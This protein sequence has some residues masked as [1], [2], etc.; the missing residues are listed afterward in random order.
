MVR[1]KMT[2]NNISS[3][4]SVEAGFDVNKNSVKA[5]KKSV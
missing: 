4:L 1:Y 3:F 5:F 2:W